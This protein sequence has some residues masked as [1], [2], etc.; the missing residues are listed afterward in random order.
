MIFGNI[1]LRQKVPPSTLVLVEEDG[2][3]H[4]TVTQLLFQIPDSWELLLC[5]PVLASY[6]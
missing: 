3:W 6:E 4:H 1:L 5:T 2:A